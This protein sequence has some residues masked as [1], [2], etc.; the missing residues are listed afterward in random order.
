MTSCEVIVVANRTPAHHSLAKEKMMEL[1]LGAGR[2]SP[3]FWTRKQPR[4]VCPDSR[5]D[6]TST[7]LPL[8]HVIT[9]CGAQDSSLGGR[10][11]DR[12]GYL[13]PAAATKSTPG[14]SHI[15]CDIKGLEYATHQRV[16]HPTDQQLPDDPTGNPIP[17]ND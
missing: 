14:R 9:R 11:C 15:P 8:V 2:G 13:Q 7:N 10:S 1:W 6:S 4:S 3:I 5:S 12:R 16:A 17:T